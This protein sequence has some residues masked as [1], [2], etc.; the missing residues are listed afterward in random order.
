V[1][2][3]EFRFP[4]LFSRPGSQIAPTLSEQDLLHWDRGFHSVARFACM[5]LFQLQEVL[6]FEP[7]TAHFRL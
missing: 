2:V 7:E 3:Q 4:I 5:G 1:D 6:H